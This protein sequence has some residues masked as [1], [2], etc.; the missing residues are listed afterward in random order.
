MQPF[1]I[2]LSYDVPNGANNIIS[3]IKGVKLWWTI[4]YRH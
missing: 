3:N 2:P 1:E 4:Y